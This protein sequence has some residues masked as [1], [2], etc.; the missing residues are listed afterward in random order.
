MSFKINDLYFYYLLHY[1]KIP[2]KVTIYF[3]SNQALRI[4][5][6][7]PIPLLP[8]PLDR[9]KSPKSE[10]Q[11]LHKFHDGKFGSVCMKFASYCVSF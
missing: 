7:L 9:L 11:Q 2:F 6:F 4:E 1:L 5:C 3:L 8:F 10:I